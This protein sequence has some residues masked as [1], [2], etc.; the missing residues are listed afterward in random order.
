MSKDLNRRQFV[1][2]SI[3]AS[4]AVTSAVSLEEKALLAQMKKPASQI[5]G[6]AK[7]LFMGKIGNVKIS[8][9]I[10]GGNLIGGYA[11]SRDLIYVSSLLNHYFTDE[12]IIETLQICEE[13]GINTIIT[14]TGSADLLKKYWNERGGKIQ[15]F[16]QCTAKTDDLLSDVKKAIDDGATGA[17]VIG[18]VG[19]NWS[20]NGRTDLI[21]KVVDYIKQNGII[22]GVGGHNLRTPMTAEKAGIDADFY[23]KTHHSTKYWSTRKPEQQED[24]IDNYK[25]DNYWDKNPEQT[26]EFMKTVKKPWIAYK[27]LAAGAIH[28]RDGFKYAFQNGAD[29]LCVGMFDFQVIEDALIARNIL[30]GKIERERP[31]RA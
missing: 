16:A 30:A 13:N 3:L 17:F 2:K 8:R 27:V 23:M 11:H 31:W 26:V 14:G 10:C 6:S 4:A 15:W 1:K 24:V 19:D 25:T 20:R 29:F 9:I 28:P 5:P 21:G 18:N 7:G 22:A 12:K